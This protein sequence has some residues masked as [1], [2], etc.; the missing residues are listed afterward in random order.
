MEHPKL[1]Y[2]AE[3]ERLRARHVK[4]GAEKVGDA[5]MPGMGAL[6]ASYSSNSSR[7]ANFFAKRSTSPTSRP[8]S[9]PSFAAASSQSAAVRGAVDGLFGP[10]AGRGSMS[11][12]GRL[13]GRL[14]ADGPFAVRGFASEAGRAGMGYLA[15]GMRP[16]S[17]RLLRSAQSETTPAGRVFSAPVRQQQHAYISTAVPI[18]IDAAVSE[19]ESS[20]TP[21]TAGR[22]A[23]QLDSTSPAQEGPSLRFASVPDMRSGLVTHDPLLGTLH[24]AR[25]HTGLTGE[26]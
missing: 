17:P 20:G 5:N 23:A 11:A 14:S 12:G 1:L 8:Q 4:P 26:Q 24:L 25:I 22:A 15:R 10:A 16:S 9:S 21:A 3:T 18:L 19:D 7:F 2:Q 6:N 13:A